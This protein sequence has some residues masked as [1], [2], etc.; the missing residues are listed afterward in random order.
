MNK[1]TIP[2]DDAFIEHKRQELRKLR[3]Q[4]VAAGRADESDAADTNAASS[5]EAHEYEDD[6]QKLTSLELDGNLVAR[7]MGRLATI[8]RALQK[9]D[10]G[11]Y[12]LSDAS[13]AA[14]PAARLDVLPDALYTIAEQEALEAKAARP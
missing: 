2:L 10:D 13:G 7:D 3:E 6:A 8:D 5:G 1:K 4:L 11:T 12:G 14:I 9:I